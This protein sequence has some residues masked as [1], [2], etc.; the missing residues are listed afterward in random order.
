MYI[1]KKSKLK[2]LIVAISA[3]MSVFS[4]VHAE[5]AATSKRSVS[6]IMLEEVVITG[7][8]KATAANLQEIPIAVT[9]YNEEQLDILHIRD[10]KGLSYNMPNVSMDEIGT[11]KGIANFSFRG[12]GIVC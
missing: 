2:Y 3:G 1:D 6:N 10:L 12:L 5:E 7:T 4:S 9:A 8:K 11:V